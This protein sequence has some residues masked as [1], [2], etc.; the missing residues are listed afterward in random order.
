MLHSHSTSRAY[1]ATI[2]PQHYNKLVRHQS[3]MHRNPPDI[4]SCILGSALP[5]HEGETA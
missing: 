5:L 3:Y 2:S 1:L 4:Y